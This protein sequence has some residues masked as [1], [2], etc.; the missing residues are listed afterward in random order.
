MPQDLG[1]A[2][3]GAATPALW[4]PKRRAAVATAHEPSVARVTAVR[5]EPVPIALVDDAA[6]QAPHGSIR[7]QSERKRALPEMREGR[8]VGERPTHRED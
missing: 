5:C 7:V 6:K 2:V 3:A 4:A 1:E 8:A